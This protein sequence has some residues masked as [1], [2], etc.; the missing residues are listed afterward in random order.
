MNA[1][2]PA[3][4]RLNAP[5]SLTGNFSWT[6]AGNVVYA[7]CQWAMLAVLAKLGTP[8][9]VGR[10]VLSLAVTAPIIMFSNLQLRAVQATDARREYQFA[11][12]LG[13]RLV[14]TLLAAVAIIAVTFLSGHKGETAAVILAVGAAKAFESISDI[15]YGLLQRHERMDYIARSMM[16]KGPLSLVALAT[17]SYVTGS[18]FWGACAMALVWGLVLV[19]YDIPVAGMVLSG[20]NGRTGERKGNRPISAAMKP[21]WNRSVL[22]SLTWC[23][24]PLGLVMMLISLNANIPRYF[25]E[26]YLGTEQLGIFAAMAYFMLAGNII[27]GALGQSA[28]PRLARH[29]AGGQIRAFRGLLMKLVGIGALLGAAGIFVT[30]VAGREVLTLLYTPQFAERAD[31]FVWI[32]AAAAVSYIA[33]FLGYGMTAARYFRVQTPLMASVALCSALACFWLV[34]KTGLSGAAWATLASGLVL[35]LGS[36]FI[37]MCAI[38]HVEKLKEH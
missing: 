11:D 29:Y 5:L 37:V 10:F 24:L 2:N 18:I 38:F 19:F 21:R 33:S 14:C 13:L 28:S 1:E 8:G 16:V 6:L 12:Y 23:S 15:Y 25:V 27:V 7:G 32:M 35:L 20:K 36:C 26:H 34:P 4:S 9:M 22:G 3:I 17:G 31:V 30:I